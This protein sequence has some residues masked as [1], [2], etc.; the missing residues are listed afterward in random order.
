MKSR[1][2]ILF[3]TLLLITGSAFSLPSVM[4]FR[5]VSRVLDARTIGENE[6]AFALVSRYWS[7]TNTFEDLH[8]RARNTASDTVLRMP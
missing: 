3:I 4:G 7:S 1:G 6:M 2:F 5:G 8:Y